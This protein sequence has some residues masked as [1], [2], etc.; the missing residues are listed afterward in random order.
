MIGYSVTK[1]GAFVTRP[2]EV[3][4]DFSKALEGVIRRASFLVR[5]KLLRELNDP[6]RRDPF[7]GVMGGRTG[8]SVR[9]GHT[10]QRI[11]PG[12][13]IYRRGNTITTAVGSP[14]QH[15]LDLEEGGTFS[16]GGGFFRIPTAAA[17][18][19]EG[20]DRWAG[21]SIRNIPGAHL[22][23]NPI[24]RKLWA[25]QVPPGGLGGAKHVLLYLL[26]RSVHRRGRH[27]FAR[28]T[29]EATPEVERDLGGTVSMQVTK[30]NAT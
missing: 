8:L 10:R 1:T 16:A 7:W 21:Q 6:P 12:G 5:S 9:T 18:T 23:R 22:Y 17:Q 27:I 13:Q 29:A 11:S 30:A 2:K 14:D 4:R 19:A 26:V 28:V 3:V 20:A 15:V 24:S 25:Y